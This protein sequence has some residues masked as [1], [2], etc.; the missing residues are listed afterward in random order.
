[1]QQNR[2]NLRRHRAS[3]DLAVKLIQAWLIYLEYEALINAKVEVGDE[4]DPNVWDR[5][6]SLIGNAIVLEP[7]LFKQLKA[8]AV[9]ARKQN[10]DFKLAVAFP[11]IYRVENHLRQFQPL[12]TI[13]LS[14][15]F[16]GN[17]RERGWDLTIDFE[18]QPVLPN[19][20]D[21]AEIDEEKAEQLVTGE[22]LLTFLSET[23]GR[24]FNT[25]EEFLNLFVLPDVP[26]TVQ[27][28]PY[29][30]RF[31][32][33]PYSYNLK[34][35][36]KKILEQRQR[37]RWVQ[38][39]HPAFEYLFGR[40][41]Q[42]T[43]QSWYA[44]AFPTHAPT[45]SQAQVL[46][47]LRSNALV[48]AVGP[49]G[50]GKTVSLSHAVAMVVCDRAIHLLQTNQ[51]ESNLTLVT[52]TNNRAVQNAESLLEKDPT[53][54][55]LFL[56][57]GSK[58]A[59]TKR[60]LPPLQAA[61][62]WL[63]D[64]PFD[65]REQQAVAAALQA[66]VE[67]LHQHLAQDEIAQQARQPLTQSLASANQQIE[68]LQQ[69]LEALNFGDSPSASTAYAEF[70][71]EAYEQIQAC[72]E[73]SDPANAVPSPLTAPQNW[74][75]RLWHPL[76]QLWFWFAQRRQ[77]S[78]SATFYQTLNQSTA[79]TQTTP[80]PIQVQLPL[81]EDTIR[82]QSSYIRTQIKAARH[83][84]ESQRISASLE[85]E[86]ANRAEIEQQL[87]SYPEQDFYA[88]FYGEEYHDLQQEI[89]HLS[90]QYLKLQALRRKGEVKASLELYAQI[91]EG[92]DRDG[93][94]YRR[95]SRQ[96]EAVY[97]DLSLLFPVISST[98][99]SI[100]NLLPF[101][102]H[103]SLAY[104]FADEAGT[105]SIHQL[106]PALVR[107]KKAL[108]V[109]DPMQLQPIMS[110]SDR[111]IQQY[112]K[113]AFQ[114]QGLS[115]K[116][117]DLYSPTAYETA[118]AYQRA[119]G[120]EGEVRGKGDGIV[121]REHFRCPPLVARLVDR[122]GG[123]GL[124]IQSLPI[125]PTLGSC[126][127][128]THIEG[129]QRNDVNQTEIDAV[130]AW[131]RLLYSRGYSFSTVDRAKTI[132]VISPYR[133]QANALRRTLQSKWRDCSEENTNT[134]HSFQGGEKAIIILSMRQSQPS[135]GLL[136]IN[137]SPNLLNVAVSR[138]TESVIL[139]GNLNRLKQGTYSKIVVDHIEQQGV[140][141]AAQDYR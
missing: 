47:Q 125:D 102:D 114:A 108:V 117:Y 139:V 59:I 20:I 12:F 132:G 17:Y 75:E 23:F 62:A 22:N 35:D 140:L 6:V 81:T 91:L 31:D 87:T 33:T 101:P 94:L 93:N 61:I 70:P 68:K 109:G 104:V 48:A 49:P 126:L 18:F 36:L 138:V 79:Q 77:R 13:D 72:L 95:F 26:Q 30:L 88:R 92:N 8:K 106:F 105:S 112:Y 96:Q 122:L 134:I 42:A 135:D 57:G 98:L 55:P 41:N 111:Q 5:G 129:V 7:G 128:A 123:Y 9:E 40:P 1:M 136:F 27:A 25:L 2:P 69:Q 73:R 86:I 84:Q 78:Q 83:W 34:K 133:K 37:W 76:K 103:G 56:S 64:T 21:V 32:F 28:I 121:L 53:L 90:H 63:D 60:M 39:G 89:F 118:S 99:H 10:N 16:Q 82:N 29:L 66:K 46:K 11:K 115:D 19:L 85:Q 116:D 44:G 71:L 50:C 113:V 124:S 107:C 67:I 58:D 110:F 141:R 80:F 120:V 130:T 119:A 131:I 24:S 54:A 127:I 45:T 97:R 15:I 38:P 100:R 65:A 137:R 74:L 3:E 43:A 14:S 52:S 4:D 51:D